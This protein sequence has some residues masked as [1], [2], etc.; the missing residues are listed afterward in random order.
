MATALRVC[1][2]QMCTSPLRDLFRQVRGRGRRRCQRREAMPSTLRRA[3]LETTL[4]VD[5][6]FQLLKFLV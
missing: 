3:H 1:K 2:L 5:Q 6:V 4:L